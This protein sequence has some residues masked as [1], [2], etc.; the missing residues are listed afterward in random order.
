VCGNFK[1]ITKGTGCKMCTCCEGEICP[2]CGGYKSTLRSTT[3]TSCPLCS[4]IPCPK[5]E[6]KVETNANHPTFRTNFDQ[7]INLSKEGKPGCFLLRDYGADLSEKDRYQP[8][9]VAPS[10]AA[11]EDSVTCLPTD[12]HC[13]NAT[14]Y[15]AAYSMVGGQSTFTDRQFVDLLTKQTQGVSF[16][17]IYLVGEHETYALVISAPTIYS[18]TVAEYSNKLGAFNN[19]NDNKNTE[20]VNNTV[21]GKKYDEALSLLKNQGVPDGDAQILAK[22]T[23]YNEAGMPVDL[24]KGTTDA[25]GNFNFERVSGKFDSSSGT[26]QVVEVPCVE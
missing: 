23:M 20:G 8:S 6:Q 3:S 24:F 13:I 9:K 21:E 22:A 10:L 16:S 19:F 11:A 18:S 26:K 1:T 5:L 17:T 14:S 15:A 2:V 25:L 7:L 12:L 4:C